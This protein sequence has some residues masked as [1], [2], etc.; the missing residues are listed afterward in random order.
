MISPMLLKEIKDKD[1]LKDRTKLFQVKE[2]GIRL[3]LHVKGGK[4]VGMF[5]RSGRPVGFLFPELREIE[6][7]GL[8]M[9]VIDGEAT[10]MD[11]NGRSV[12]YG[13]IDQRSHSF[14]PERLKSH[15]VTFLPFDLIYLNGKSIKHKPYSERLQMLQDLVKPIKNLKVVET[16]NDGEALWNKV[17]TEDREGIVIKD[18]NAPYEEGVRSN[19]YQKLKNYKEV[20][21]TVDK[22][23][24]N[25]KGLKIYG[26][27]TVNG[28]TVDVEAQCAGVDHIEIGTQIKVTYMQ[29]TR[30]KET[31]RVSVRQ[32][33]ITKESKI[34]GGL[35]EG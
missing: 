2:D 32:P 33:V 22:T 18:P 27:G 8:D 34:E 6:F 7:P 23:E 1:E 14:H 28:E 9:A 3:L 11:E 17:K 24:E 31:G 21:V 10:V 5:S 29:V 4:V 30:N 35:I 20:V 15:P 12:F 25:P 13:G 16:S 19:R 26:T